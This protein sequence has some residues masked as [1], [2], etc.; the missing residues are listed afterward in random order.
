MKRLLLIFLFLL[1]LQASWAA[2]GAYAHHG[3]GEQSH[4]SALHKHQHADNRSSDTSPDKLH[5]HCS[6]SHIGGVALPGFFQL[7][8]SSP[9]ESFVS[10]YH[11]VRLPQPVSP[12]PERPNWIS[13]AS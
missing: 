6:F 3:E 13:A 1:P 12:R 10:Q 4:H 8:F 2:M 11:V 5:H 7:N 9:V